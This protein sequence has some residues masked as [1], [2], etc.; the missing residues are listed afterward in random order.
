MKLISQNTK[1]GRSKEMK[2]IKMCTIAEH[3]TI[4]H[5]LES[6]VQSCIK[7][8]SKDGTIYA[9]GAYIYSGGFR[10]IT[11]NENTVFGY[12]YNVEIAS[13][14]DDMVDKMVS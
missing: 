5:M 12:S 6:E 4:E 3:R 10:V 11:L 2:D 9:Y 14:F 7:C 13:S 1:E 8:V